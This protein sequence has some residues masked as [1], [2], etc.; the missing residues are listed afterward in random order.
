MATALSIGWGLFLIAH[1]LVHLVY[2]APSD[3]PDFPMTAGKSWLVT[4]AGMSLG[5]IRGV[6]AV[7]AIVSLVGFVLL[8]LSFWGLLVPAAWFEPLAIVAVAASLLLIAIT[9]NRQFVFGVAI[10]VVI[11]YWALALGREWIATL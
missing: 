1:G 10:D 9:W 4:G 2:F 3:D 6:V 5:T 8:A 7:L 11:L